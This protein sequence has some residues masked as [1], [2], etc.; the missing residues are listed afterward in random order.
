ML[1]HRY[2]AL[3]DSQTEGMNDLDAH[4]GIRGWADRF[5][6]SLAECNPDLLYANLA[7]RGRRTK[8]IRADQLEPALALNPDLASVMAGANDVLGSFDLDETMS[9]LEDMY[10]EFEQGMRQVEDDIRNAS[11]VATCKLAVPVIL[12]GTKFAGSF[13]GLMVDRRRRVVEKARSKSSV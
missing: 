11:A 10:R 12:S 9:D 5:A 2:V 13:V 4:G 1:F 3:G 7:I 6:V 8:R